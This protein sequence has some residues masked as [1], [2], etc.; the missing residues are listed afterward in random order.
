M[1][2]WSTIA[3][4]ATAGGTL[5]LALAT[6]ASVR[7]ANRSARLAEYSMQIGIRPLLMPSRLE[8]VA[9]KIMWGDEHWALLPGGGATVEVVDGNVYLAMSLRNSG[10]GIGVIHGWHLGL[11]DLHAQHAHAEPNEFRPQLRDLYVPGGDISFWQGAIRDH[12]DPEY[13]PLVEAVRSSR[14]FRIELLYTDHEGAQRAITEFLL[15]PGKER[16]L[17][18]AIRHWNLDRPDPR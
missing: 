13:A 4:L 14:M 3:S 1:T 18:S 2:D 17:C 10:S 8:D 16:W 6:F 7:S 9:Q 5:V 12:D 11:H 15:A